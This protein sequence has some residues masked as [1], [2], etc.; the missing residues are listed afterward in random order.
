MGTTFDCFDETARATYARLSPEVR[1]NRLLLR[2]AMERSGFVAYEPEWWHF[3]LA[4]EPFRDRS[5]DD[6]IR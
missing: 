1:R 6:E 5:F 2:L 3:T 4:D